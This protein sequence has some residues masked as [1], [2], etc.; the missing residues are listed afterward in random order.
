MAAA[1]PAPAKTTP[2]AAGAEE[3]QINEANAESADEARWQPVLELPCDLIVELPLP[4]F[5]IAD[6][7]QLRAG[8]VID[9]DLRI[10]RDVP[11]RLNGVL[12]GWVEF[13]VMGNNLAVRL[14]E[15]A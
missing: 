13:E 7:L 15:L 11:L 4:N 8:S 14:T 6:F 5:D 10:G 12:I 9:A 2:Q 1:A 3:I